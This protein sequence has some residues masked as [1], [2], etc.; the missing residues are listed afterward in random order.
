[1]AKLYF[2]YGAMG[3]SKTANALMVQ[4]NY[5][6]KGQKAVLLKPG[7]DT[8]DGAG[9][10]RSRIGLEAEAL[11]V[12]DYLEMVRTEWMPFLK[13]FRLTKEDGPW[14]DIAAIIVDE[15]QFLT[16]SQ[17]EL[18]S[19]I[20]DWFGISVICYGLRTDFRSHVFEGSLR[21]L[22]LVWSWSAPRASASISTR[23]GAM[24]PSAV[25]ISRK[26]ISDPIRL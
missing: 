13:D 26:G 2:R 20:V 17:V 6:E 1:M 23:R 25:S 9:M 8:R 3:S 19:D 15:A 4:Y 22:E 14:K 16:A 21:L 10:V 7:I 12:E 5:M 24:F 18:L 11:Y